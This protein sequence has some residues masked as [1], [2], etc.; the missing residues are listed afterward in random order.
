M[1]K[2]IIRFKDLQDN[3]HVYNVGDIFPHKGVNVNKK[4]IKELSSDKNRRG[5]PLIEEV[6][7]DEH[8]DV[9]RSLSGDSKLV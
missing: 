8:G 5:V 7:K 6:V 3:N 2:V 4:R 1:Y 9:D